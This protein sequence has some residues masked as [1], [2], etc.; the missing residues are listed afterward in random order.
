MRWK[1]SPKR[2][3]VRHGLSANRERPSLPQFQP[4]PLSGAPR[5]RFG[6]ACYCAPRNR[7][8][9]ARVGHCL[10]ASVRTRPE[11]HG[12]TPRA[13][14]ESAFFQ[15]LPKNI[16]DVQV[17]F[18]LIARYGDAPA[19]PMSPS[20]AIVKHYRR[21]RAR[22]RSNLRSYCSRL[23]FFTARFALSWNWRS[24]SR[25]ENFR[26][27]FGRACDLTIRRRAQQC[28]CRRTGRHPGRGLPP[29]L[30]HKTGFWLWAVRTICA[31]PLCPPSNAQKR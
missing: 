20:K 16:F 9:R 15:E 25:Q 4:G 24:R 2:R 22:L 30:S 27:P 14:R 31:W 5:G 3:C 19:S 8:G 12:R 11:G 21:T 10:R 7:E 29:M 26:G 17:A 1:T 28:Q 18:N 6:F 23:L 13:N